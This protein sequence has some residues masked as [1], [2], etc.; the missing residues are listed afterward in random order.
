MASSALAI[1]AHF[2][3]K[4]TFGTFNAGS[5]TVSFRSAGLGND[6]PN[7]AVFLTGEVACVNGGNHIPKADNKS[8]VGGGGS[9]AVVNGAASGTIDATGSPKCGAGQTLVYQN[10]TVWINSTGVQDTSTA[11]ASLNLGSFS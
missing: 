7:V 9:F 2:D 1:S 5:L 4:N 10:I 6:V 3:R 11:D 8:A